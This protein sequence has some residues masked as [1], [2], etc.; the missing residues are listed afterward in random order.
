MKT[1]ILFSLL[2]GLLLLAAI[3]SPVQADGIIIPDFPPGQP[4]P[5]ETARLVIRYHHVTVRIENQLAVTRVD[6]VFYNPHD[7][8]V[9]GTYLFPLPVDA[10]VSNFV[11]WIDGKPVE[12][13]VLD[14]TQARR[15]YEEIVRGMRDPAL[16]EYV[17][18]GAVQARIFPIPPQGER[19]VEL[20]YTQ[21]LTADNGLVRYLYPLNTEKFSAEPLQSVT[22]RVEVSAA[23]PV[24][25]VY[26]PSHNV[27]IKRSD[28][29]HFV[30][31]YEASNVTP[32]ADFA[33][34]YSL[35][36]S[37][38]FHLFS[39][40][41]PGDAQDRDGFFLML[42]APKPGEASQPVAKDLL[43]VL[44][45]SGSMEGEKFQ[46]AQA[47]VRYILQHLNPGD[48]FH[49]TTF[50]NF[51][52]RYAEGL[53]PAADA[54]AATGWLNQM[55]AVGSTDINRALLEAASLADRERPTYLIFLTD[56]L[57]TEGE[58]DSQKILNNFAQT[59]PRNV[60]LFAFGVGYDVDT[61]LLD[62]LSQEHHGVSTYVQPG[63]ALDE[64]L[65]SFYARISTPVLTNL[66]LDFGALSVYDLYPDPLPD[67]FAG[68]QVVV[69]GRYREGGVTTVTLKG[70]VNGQA[71]V[72]RY[73][74]QRFT[75]DGRGQSGAL[76]ELPRLW[77]TRKIG[78]LLSKIRLQGPDQ[79][80]IDQIVRLSVRYGIVT[81]YTS[82]LVTEQAPLGAASQ[83]ELARDAYNDLQAAPAAPASGQEAV[84]KAAGQGA[85]SQ[86]E[87]APSASQASGQ[88]VR[89]V[90]SRTFVLNGGVWVDTSYDPQVMKPTPVVFLS[91]D[92]FR[93]SQS[94]PEVAAALALGERVI[95]VVDGAAYEV[96]AAGEPAGAAPLVLPAT[97]V[98][99]PAV[100][101][102]TATPQNVTTGSSTTAPAVPASPATPEPCASGAL[103]LLL[104]VVVWRLRL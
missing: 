4:P 98:P 14:A 28:D 18:R 60:R 73:A 12:G 21:A 31:S 7:W 32:D 26:S 25:A 103:P 56:G 15:T 63:E 52:D 70:E 99:Q 102:A 85:M 55:S 53:R 9:E 29:R 46:Q 94:R 104:A 79:E 57:P 39:Y 37:E 45:R 50:N 88:R 48:R 100:S 87:V 49:L 78:Y 33:L 91:Q 38:A 69:V 81:P 68:S 42:L 20:E 40:R 82:Y 64:V 24:R 90:G 92:Y 2:A 10:T 6:Q 17:G 43:L 86:A 5:P 8:Q 74:E 59:A 67:L 89:I 83:Q 36:E 1:R 35:G 65:S 34:Y 54:G 58:T 66:A 44:D 22:V 84:E 30:A 23:Q 93:L 72:F 71:Q 41:D 19:R 76:V 75:A 96:V 62:S 47:A 16:L 3:A 11:L 101:A 97:T 80:T 13:K 27:S 77:A 51:T 95:V 61:Y